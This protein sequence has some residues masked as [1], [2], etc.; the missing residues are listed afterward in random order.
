MG[1]PISTRRWVYWLILS[2]IWLSILFVKILPLNLSAG[3]WPGPDLLLAFAFAWVLRRPDYVPALLLALL[4]LMSDFLF[5]RPPGLMAA[6]AVM[7]LEFLR[8]RAQFSRDL[9][10]L[11][12]WAMVAGV[13]VALVLVNRVILLIF[14]ISQ[15]SFGLDMIQVTATILFYPVVVAISSYILGVRKVA[16]GEVDQLGHRI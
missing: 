1:D 6:L 3:R 5:M 4:I 8:S 15:P 9:P 14:V 12:E 11:V 7:G 2:A 10:F 16:P 13:V